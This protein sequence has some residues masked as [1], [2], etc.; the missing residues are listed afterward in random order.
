M[1]DLARLCI[2]RTL[3]TPIYL[4]MVAA[5]FTLLY[6]GI[7]GATGTWLWIALGLPGDR[8]RRVCRLRLQCPLTA[9][10]VRYGARTGH[11]FD[12]LLPESVA[13]HTFQVFGTLMGIGLVLLGAR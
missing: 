11:V 5:T 9:L 2:V 8:V 1:L 10:A 12:T 6:R 7:S 13:R 3:H 4:V